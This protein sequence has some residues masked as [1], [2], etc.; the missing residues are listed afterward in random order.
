[1]GTEVRR[2]IEF[3]DVEL[4]GGAELVAPVKKATVGYSYGEGGPRT[5][6]GCKSKWGT[7]GGMKS[8][9]AVIIW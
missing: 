2:R 6:E 1:L 5:G 8:T 3:I 4:G 7:C 9:V